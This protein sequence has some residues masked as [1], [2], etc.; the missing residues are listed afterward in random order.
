[1]FEHDAM[2]GAIHGFEAMALVIV[3]ED[4]HV[5]LVVL[6]MARRLP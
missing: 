3:L 2:G 1:M 5:V 4:E 6:V